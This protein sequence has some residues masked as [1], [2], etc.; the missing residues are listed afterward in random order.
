MAAIANVSA[1]TVSRVLNH[2]PS[3]RSETRER[4]MAAVH[5]SGYLPNLAARSLARG[6]SDSIG[7]LLTASLTHGIG[8]TFSTLAERIRSRG[9]QVI[10][11]TAD[12]NSS[13]SIRRALINLRGYRVA[14]IIVLA[15]RGIILHQL[16]DELHADEPMVVVMDTRSPEPTLATVGIDQAKG[17]RLATQHL[18]SQ[19]RHK[20]LHIS[21][22]L[23]WQDASERLISYHATCAD[24]GLKSPTVDAGGWSSHD[25]A[26]VAQRLLMS[27]HV[28]D[29]IFAANDDIALGLLHEFLDAGVRVPD[30]VAIVG[31]D[32]IPQAAWTT[33]SLTTISQSFNQIG[34]SALEMADDLANG[35]KPTHAR[36]SPQLVVRES[37][38]T[39]GQ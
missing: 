31:F 20:L 6:T 13:S 26:A 4:V 27:G 28:P 21:G 14:S 24:A 37:T 36:L 11:E 29:G 23:T 2:H 1:Q 18:I 32:D 25:G 3:V 7:I 38:N 5:S 17:A 30:D 15:R 33:P 22:D 10:L 16:A 8:I 39:T 9:K 12:E 35:G 34:L 19:G